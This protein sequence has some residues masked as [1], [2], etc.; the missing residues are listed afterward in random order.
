M[1]VI[2]ELIQ[3]LHQNQPVNDFFNQHYDKPLKHLLGY[4]A[5]PTSDEL[6]LLCYVPEETNLPDRYGRNRKIQI[7]ICVEDD[8]LLDIDLNQIQEDQL[9]TEPIQLFSGSIRSEQAQD[10]IIEELKKAR[11]SNGFFIDNEIAI[12]TDLTLGYPFFQLQINLTALSKNF[13]ND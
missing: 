5:S 2:T 10:L 8:R 13:E 4:K 1:S 9:N 6:P 3:Y 11:L 12:K 7:I